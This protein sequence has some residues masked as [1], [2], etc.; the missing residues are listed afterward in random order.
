[1]KT[2]PS[3]FRR[4]G[5]AFRRLAVSGRSDSGSSGSLVSLSRW[6]RETALSFLAPLVVAFAFDSS[7][8]AGWDIE[9]LCFE[10]AAGDGELVRWRFGTCLKLVSSQH[11]LISMEAH[12]F[13][14]IHNGKI[15]LRITIAPTPFPS[16]RWSFFGRRL[17]VFLAFLYRTSKLLFLIISRISTVHGRATF[18]IGSGLGALRPP[19]VSIS[20]RVSRGDNG[21]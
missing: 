15:N 7:S 19:G 17:G 2:S 18:R 16:G 3:P 13:R 20:G 5:R 12:S 14:K 10:T 11:R 1:M 6:F 21:G 8:D 4:S 9:L